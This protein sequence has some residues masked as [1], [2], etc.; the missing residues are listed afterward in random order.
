MY[1]S[2]ELL[3]LRPHYDVECPF[4]TRVWVSEPLG[5]LHHNALSRLFQLGEVLVQE[6]VAGLAAPAVL[7]LRPQ[8]VTV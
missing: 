1:T 3:R 8:N 4:Q 6:E 5:S 2:P 7:A